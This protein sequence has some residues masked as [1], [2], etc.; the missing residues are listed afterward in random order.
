MKTTNVKA[1]DLN[2]DHYSSD[3]YD[4]YIINSIPAHKELHEGIVKFVRKGYIKSEEYSVLDLGVGTGI[5]SKI[6]QEE[7]PGSRFDLVDFSKNMLD[8]AKKKFRDNSKVRYILADYSEMEFD[9][10]YD[11]VVSV[12]GFHHQTDIGKKKMFKKIYSLLNS[13]G[14]FVLGD[15]VTYKDRRKAALSSALH[16]HQ[17]VEKASDKKTLEEWAFHHIELNKLSPLE[18]QVKWLEEVGFKVS[19]KMQKMNTVLIICRK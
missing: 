1:V 14:I 16:F 13:G 15:L 18:D 19:V 9:R 2:Y 7:L 8:G 3:K 11:L 12:I 10:E 4:Q 17:L 6:I 5:T